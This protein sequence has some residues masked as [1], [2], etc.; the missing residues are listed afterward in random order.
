MSNGKYKAS[1]RRKSSDYMDEVHKVRY[2]DSTD[3]ERN[4]YNRARE[5]LGM[6]D[7]HEDE[8]VSADRKYLMYCKHLV[9][10]VQKLLMSTTNVQNIMVCDLAK[11]VHINNAIS[12]AN[13]YRN[14][15]AIFRDLSDTIMKLPYLKPL[16][17][18]DINELETNDILYRVK[19]SCGYRHKGKNG[20]YISS[21]PHKKQYK[22]VSKT[23]PIVKLIKD[24][25][26]TSTLG[27]V[28]I[29]KYEY[30]KLGGQIVTNSIAQA[31]SL[32]TL[33]GAQYI[34]PKGVY[35]KDESKCGGALTR[36]VILANKGVEY[37]CPSDKCACGLP[38]AWE[39]NL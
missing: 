1:L 5:L 35:N 28:Q 9:D 23:H 22:H 17:L 39:N 6:A 18:D 19:M 30:T 36:A 15:N 3:R 32:N 38:K 14:S 26:R 24:R 8:Y 13:E 16:T 10:K 25:M 27:N 29:H 2:N 34:V 12:T 37:T 4:S 21:C 11:L 31:K 7:V 20:K 33:D